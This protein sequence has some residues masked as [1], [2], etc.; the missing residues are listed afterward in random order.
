[1]SKPLSKRMSKFLSKRWRTLA[2]LTTGSRLTSRHRRRF[3]VVWM[4]SDLWGHIHVGNHVQVYTKMNIYM[5]NTF[6]ALFVAWQQCHAARSQWSKCFI[7]I[8]LLWKSPSSPWHPPITQCFDFMQKYWVACS[9][10]VIFQ[11][12]IW[13]E[14]IQIFGFDI[15]NARI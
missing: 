2:W 8:S 7:A 4:P 10:E 11:T 15:T 13:W 5:N 9:W 6:F 14:L 12:R 1:M 3:D